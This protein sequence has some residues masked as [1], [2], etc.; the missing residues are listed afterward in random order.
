[1]LAARVSIQ[2]IAAF[3]IEEDKVLTG[4]FEPT[5]EAYALAK[6]SGMRYCQYINRQH[7]MNFIVAVP[8]NL[9]GINDHYD[10]ESSHLLPA[11]IHKIH[12]AKETGENTLEIWGSGNPRR[13]FLNSDDCADAL[14]YLMQNYSDSSP[15]NIGLGY[16]Y[17]IA[18]WGHLVMGV[19]DANLEIQ[20]DASKPDGI[21]QKLLDTTKLDK[22]GLENPS[23]V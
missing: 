16:D 13:E 19:L 10:L 21:F 8:C 18:E 4:P 14:I 15:V 12:A 7:G 5:N 6:A 20:F 3:P 2:P 1:M 23:I 22:L 9:F 17:S 11:L